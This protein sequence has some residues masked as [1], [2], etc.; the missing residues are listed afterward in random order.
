MLRLAHAP[1][2]A[3]SLRKLDELLS[4]RRRFP[5]LKMLSIEITVI[6]RQRWNANG[7]SVDEDEGASSPSSEGE[8][9]L[10]ALL[11]GVLDERKVQAVLDHLKARHLASLPRLMGMQSEGMVEVHYNSLY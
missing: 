5:S 4:D 7:E 3:K 6:K 2:R 8:G 11:I 9:T 1:L 10:Q